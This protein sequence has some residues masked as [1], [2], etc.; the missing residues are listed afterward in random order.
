LTVTHKVTIYSCE[1]ARAIESKEAFNILVAKV[2]HGS[3]VVLPCT[4][5]PPCRILGDKE[6]A[7]L[8]TEV[9]NCISSIREK[10]R[11]KAYEKEMAERIPLTLEDMCTFTAKFLTAKSKQEFTV[12]DVYN[13]SPDRNLAYYLDLYEESVFATGKDFYGRSSFVY[14]DERLLSVK[15][16]P[17]LRVLAVR[18]TNILT[19]IQENDKT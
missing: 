5:N 7:I 13:L 18:Y 11:K 14:F 6:K 2:M 1:Y 10:Q 16:D 12:T 8:Q 9:N 17:S 19:K 4:C 15:D 3:F